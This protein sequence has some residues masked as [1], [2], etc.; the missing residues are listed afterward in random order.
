M[1]SEVEIIISI[2]SA[3]EAAQLLCDSATVSITFVME[4][5]FRETYADTDFFR[6]FGRVRADNPQIQ[7][8]CKGSKINVHP[9][10]MSSQMSLGLKAY[11]LTLGKPASIEDVIYIFDYDEDNLTNDPNEQRNFYRRWIESDKK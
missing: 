3:K 8:L 6:C 2:D 10:S 4:N 1:K 5:G 9:S 7:F 11:E